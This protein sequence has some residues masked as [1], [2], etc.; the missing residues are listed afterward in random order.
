MRV[1]DRMI[2]EN[3]RRDTM[4]ARQRLEDATRE[5][6]TGMRVTHPWDDPAATGLLVQRRLAG[7]RWDAQRTSVER[8]A[9]EL[10]VADS[11]LDSVANAVSRAQQ[12]AV[13]LSNATYSAGD[14]AGAA[15]EVQGLISDVIGTLNRQVGNRYIFGGTADG[16]PPFDATGAY[17]GDANV[18]SV[19]VMPGVNVN[20]SVRADVYLQGSG[21][22]VDVLDTLRTLQ[23]ALENN[24]PAA[25]SGT[26]DDLATGVDQV[27]RARAEAGANTLL[28]DSAAAAARVAS[29]Q[30]V[31]AGAALSEVDVIDAAT[32]L[33][34]AERALE[35]ALAATSRS[36]AKTLLDTLR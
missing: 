32:R 33:A 22:G 27:A 18:R 36:F 20:T 34:H 25:I 28:L 14:R 8:A 16:A 12:L 1:T 35:A 13:Q 26:L 29:D 6:S 9:D 2:F 30:E 5:A 7:A 3:A 15:R 11:A 31:V 21:G 10:S 17:Q 19:E 24:D 23:A 4:A